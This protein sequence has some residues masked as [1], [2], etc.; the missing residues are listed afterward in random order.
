MWWI[1]K[2]IHQDNKRLRNVIMVVFVKQSISNVSIYN[3]KQTIERKIDP[4]IERTN[5]SDDV[6]NNQKNTSRQQQTVQ[7]D[8]DCVCET[9]DFEW[10]H[11]M[12]EYVL[13]RECAKQP[14]TYKWISVMNTKQR[15]SK[16]N[17]L[18][19]RR[20]ISNEWSYE[21]QVLIFTQWKLNECTLITIDFN[22]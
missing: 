9:I 12:S 5:A 18:F 1:I 7:Y 16:G 3:D 22:D 6:V 10:E 14:Y 4:Y 13:D 17:I 20:R 11:R 15:T 21:K 8:F 19:Q 2:R